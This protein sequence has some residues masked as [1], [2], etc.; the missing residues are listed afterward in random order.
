[1]AEAD[2]LTGLPVGEPVCLRPLPA[3]LRA[4]LAGRH[5]TLDA[6]SPDDADALFAATQGPG[7]EA[8]WQYLREPPCPDRAAFAAQIAD[9]AAS[10]D[11][12]FFAIR[13]GGT[14]VGHAA[15]MRMDVPN[16]V[17]E[18]G[19]IL[20]APAL[21]RTPA[22]TEAIR[23]LLGHVFDTLGMR[24]CEWKCDALNAAS[25]RAALRLG[26]AYEGTF[27]QHMVVKGRNRDT[28][29]FALLDREW[30]RARTALDAWLDPANFD[31]TGGQRRSLGAIRAAL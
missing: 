11:P 1:M 31:A 4:T 10:A 3:S 16:R 26:F 18:I 23:L 6:L 20:F 15:L 30:P 2:P 22:A 13:R 24:R 14:A 25:R 9:K 27:R 8:L 19:H 12:L 7:T 5:V 21:Q 28:A 29:W 17:I